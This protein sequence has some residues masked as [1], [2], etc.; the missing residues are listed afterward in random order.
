MQKDKD[1]GVKELIG[2]SITKT[3][4]GKEYGGH[5]KRYEKPYY[6]VEYEDGDK[7][8]LTQREVERS[9]TSVDDQTQ[10]SQT[11]DEQINS[12]PD[13]TDTSTTQVNTVN[14]VF[15]TSFME[16]LQH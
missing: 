16:R 3:F 8:D 10:Q 15:N 14:E 7:E 12:T 13:Q 4:N 11:P 2:R 1:T 5:V 9:L 6:V